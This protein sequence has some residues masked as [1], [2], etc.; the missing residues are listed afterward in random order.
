MRV[1]L[2]MAD[3]DSLISSDS[4]TIVYRIVQ[5]ALTNIGKH[6]KAKNVAIKINEDTGVV[7]FSIEDDG[8]GFSTADM[9]ARGPEEKGLGL[10]TMRG[11]AQMLGGTLTVRAREGR[12]TR[13]SMQIPMRRGGTQP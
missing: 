2:D 4:H 9:N 6:S 5:E 11:R 12:G 7:S 13:I 3:L 1:S 10:A 8:R